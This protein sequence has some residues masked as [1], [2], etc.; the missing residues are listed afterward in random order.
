MRRNWM[1]RILQADQRP[2]Q[3]PQRRELAGST[4]RTIPFGK[5]I[6]TDVESGE[7]SVSDYEVSKKLIHLLCHV[8]V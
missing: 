2:K 1:R 8:S 6:W 4:T 7:Y 5:R 3:K